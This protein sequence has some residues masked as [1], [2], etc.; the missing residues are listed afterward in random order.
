MADWI[1]KKP[2]KM[3]DKKTTAKWI[4]KKPKEWITKRPKKWITKKPTEW[5]KKREQPKT[6]EPL[7]PSKRRQQRKQQQDQSAKQHLTE[8]YSYTGIPGAKATAKG[9]KYNKEGYKGG[10]AVLK[11][12]KVGIQIK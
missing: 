5:I 12:K 1:T 9:V 8:D 4:E 2:K 10:G 6:K 7:S 3:V 11:G